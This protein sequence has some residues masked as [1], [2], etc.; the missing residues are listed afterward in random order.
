MTKCVGSV[1]D[2]IVLTKK[3]MAKLKNKPSV[4]EL[5]EEGKIK[6]VKGI[7]K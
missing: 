1:V 7:K 3:Q 6:K 5:T 2:N 4:F